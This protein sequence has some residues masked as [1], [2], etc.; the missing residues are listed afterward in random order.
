MQDKELERI[1]QE[2]AD[3]TE[4]RPFSEVWEDIK[5]DVVQPE[6]KKKKFELK[7]WLP[8]SLAATFLVACIAVTPIIIES[9]KPLP[10]QEELFFTDELV[11]QNTTKEEMFQGLSSAQIH[12]VD[13]SSYSFDSCKLYYTENNVVKGAEFNFYENVP[14]PSFFAKMRIYDKSVD[15]NLDLAKYDTIVKVNSADVHYK[16]NGQNGGMYQYEV[17][18]VHNSVQY[19][20]EYNGFADNLM[21]F[22]NDFFA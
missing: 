21:E 1:L 5:G 8:M 10:P 12:H 11:I 17:Y 13:L 20:I 15:L 14:I 19:A 3:K 4:M 6:P 7:K 9:L 2:K 22:L 18:A 16:F